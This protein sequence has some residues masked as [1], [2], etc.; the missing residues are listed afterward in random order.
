MTMK[1]IPLLGLVLTVQAGLA[2]AGEPAALAAYLEEL[3]RVEQSAHPQ[4]LEPLFIKAGQAQDALMQIDGSFAEGDFAYIEKLSEAEYAAIKLRM[5]GFIL[6]REGAIYAQPDPAVL[7]D[8][9]L[10]HGT[11]ADQAF[12][13]LHRNFW[14]ASL[15]PIYLKS[16]GDVSGCVRY[17]EG[18][19]V[20]LYEDW[21]RY[22]R[23]YPGQ[24][25]EVV[26][27]T[28]ADLE[29]TVA[30]GTC[31]CGDAASVVRELRTFARRYPMS[32]VRKAAL[33]RVREIENDAMQLP[34]ACR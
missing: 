28:L 21:Q 12:F 10:A 31:A 6:A 20:E 19:V 33:T 17:G 8:L 25:T 24:Y 7:L 5:R 15:F 18:I 27:Q 9:A 16:K 11:P 26:R 32:R 34:I 2:P 4:S 14:G 30:L 1:I 13:Q 22:A 23:S 3:E 29:D